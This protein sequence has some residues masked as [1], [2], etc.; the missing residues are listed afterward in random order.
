MASSSVRQTTKGQSVIVAQSIKV[1]VAVKE[2]SPRVALIVIG[3]GSGGNGFPAISL[4]LNCALRPMTGRPKS[5][6]LF[7]TGGSI[8]N[9]FGVT[10]RM[11][12]GSGPTIEVRVTVPVARSP[13]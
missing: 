13:L 11:T 5:L 2:L 8:S 3:R 10:F 1:T 4:N 12:G 6:P 7:T 9:T